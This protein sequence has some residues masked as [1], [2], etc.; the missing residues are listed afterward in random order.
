MKIEEA[1]IKK[2][3]VEVKS[4]LLDQ[5]VE[6]VTLLWERATI[7]CQARKAIKTKLA[8][9]IDAAFDRVKKINAKKRSDPQ[10]MQEE[11]DKFETLSDLARCSCFSKC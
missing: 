7:P 9:V 3:T 11:K 4:A 8:R 5:V 2:L 6:E 1:E 10:V